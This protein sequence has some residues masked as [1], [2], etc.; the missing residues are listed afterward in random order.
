MDYG[1]AVFGMQVSGRSDQTIDPRHPDGMP[2]KPLRITF[3][4][5]TLG[6]S[7]GIRCV[8]QLAKALI[9]RGNQVHII[10][11]KAYR[12]GWLPHNIGQA[13][14]KYHELR[15]RIAGRDNHL[16]LQRVPYI[17]SRGPGISPDEAP[18]ADIVI[19]TWWKSV[20]ELENWPDSKGLKS[21]YVQGHD[22][23][24][25]DKEV[26]SEVYLRPYKKFAV[27]KWLVALLE[28]A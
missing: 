1:V 21:H 8:G 2:N 20:Q 28:N 16:K 13:R 12:L 26:I 6:L 5:S 14:G 17:T 22:I 3:V 11:G 19:G 10:A 15:A 27:S 18:E 23:Y 4:L 9:E 7:G 24:A 25:G